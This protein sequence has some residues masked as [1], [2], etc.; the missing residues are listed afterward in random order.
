[1]IEILKVKIL[2]NWERFN[3]LIYFNMLNKLNEVKKK[4]Y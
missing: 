3:L 1:M 4:D 2:Y